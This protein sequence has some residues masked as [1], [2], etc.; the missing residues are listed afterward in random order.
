[1]QRLSFADDYRRNRRYCPPTGLIVAQR[2]TGR[3]WC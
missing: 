2:P 3:Q 1:M